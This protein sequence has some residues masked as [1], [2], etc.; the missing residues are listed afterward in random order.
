MPTHKQ[1]KTDDRTMIR[2]RQLLIHGKARISFTEELR[3]E[4]PNH[5]LVPTRC[6]QRSS[7]G[8]G[9]TYMRT[10]SQRFREMTRMIALAITVFTCFVVGGFAEE[11]MDA[12]TADISGAVSWL[13][14]EADRIVR[15][16]KR[17]MNDGTSAFPPQ[18]GIGY[19]AFWL[20]D[21][22]Y[23]IPTRRMQAT[24]CSS[25]LIRGVDSWAPP[26][27]IATGCIAARACHWGS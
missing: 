17:E 11:N 26:V 22:E 12:P 24:R 27:I 21:Y 15:A 9:R 13:E 25:R 19:E 8:T 10:K 5:A 18:V 23:K 1:S 16:S 20:R 2:F 7:H 3:T 4:F 14:K 6:P